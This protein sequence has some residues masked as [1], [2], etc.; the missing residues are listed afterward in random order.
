VNRLT[1]TVQYAAEDVGAAHLPERKSVRVWAK[2][3]LPKPCQGE[4]TIRL[5]S[6]E[7]GRQLN[8]QYRG[9]DYPTNVL[10]FPYSPL[11]EIAGDLAICP[12]VVAREA[13][14]QEKPL[15]A[16]YA[17]LIVH[18]LLHLQGYDHEDVAEAE[19][20]EAREREILAALGFPD[21]YLVGQSA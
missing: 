3:A 9:K 16:H 5:V 15:T 19:R 6:A 17:H 13:A 12:V 18:G 20:M 21:P 14:E 7:E 1:L 4:V 2:A 8:S 11:P 10:S